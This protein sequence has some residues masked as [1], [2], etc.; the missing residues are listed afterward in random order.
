MSDTLSDMVARINNGQTAKLNRVKVINSKLNISV[1]KILKNEGFINDFTVVENKETSFND[2]F[3]T[4][5]YDLG[6]PVIKEFKR[7]SKPGRR[8]YCKSSKIPKFYNGLGISILSTS[9]G[10]LSN[11]EASLHNIGG[12]LLCTVF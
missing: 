7:V 2:V 6:S 12:E 5:K 11:D 10:V 3:V 1:L 4:L 9:K 8:I